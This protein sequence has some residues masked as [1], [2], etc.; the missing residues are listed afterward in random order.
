MVT[1]LIPS[2][3]NGLG[4]T[5]TQDDPV[6]VE[7]GK[8]KLTS[9][10]FQKRF[11][12]LTDSGKIPA[13][14]MQVY[15]PQYL[16]FL[17]KQMTARYQAERM[18][19]TVSDDEILVGLMA[20]NPQYFPNG[21]MG[22]D[23][24]AQYEQFLAQQ[25]GTLDDAIDETRGNLLVKK[26]ND[27]ILEAIVVTP[28]EVEAEFSKK[29]ERARIAYIAFPPGKFSDQV[30]PTEDDLHK[31]FN[32]NRGN[33]T[34]PQKTSFQ[35]VVLDQEKVEA[36][37]QFS[38]AELRKAYAGALDNFRMP[39]R[40]HVRH[41]LINAEG[42]SDA[43]KKALKTKAEDLLKQL[44][45]GADFA[46]LAKKNSQ[47]TASAEKGGDLDWL[48]RGQSGSPEFEAA[49]FA[50]KPKDFS[51][52]IT[53]QYGFQIA[54]VLEK[55]P[56]RVK[57]FEEVKAG[58]AV[59]LRKQMVPD[60]VQ[61]L[62]DQIHA[63]LQK[64][65]G[66]AEAV[67]K[68]FGADVITVP[69][70]TPGQAIPTLGASPEIDAV[71]AKMKPN[72]V[73]AVMPLPSNRLA[74]VVLTSRTPARNAEFN[75]VAEQ[76]RNSYLQTETGLVAENKAKEAA[77]R[78]R[79]G[80][81]MEKVA[82]AYKMELV[83]SSY[84]GRSDAV[85]GLGQAVYVQDAFT[86]PAGTIIGPAMIRDKNEN[87]VYKVLDKVGADPVAL[88]AEKDAIA[89]QIKERKAHEREDLMLD[90]IETRLLAEGKMKRNDKEILRVMG[91][92]APK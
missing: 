8:Y 82:K 48:V 4:T 87:I 76:V 70:A 44:K 54:Q 36:T 29:N 38:D 25:G 42:K 31:A 81:D 21:V 71:L 46:E 5:T 16:D 23:Q 86:K 64:S 12:H 78:V 88:A 68:Q 65:P 13:E 61:A 34:I 35:V 26:L 32:A 18:G 11:S 84:F 69:N 51:G 2:F 52:V 45:A 59:D 89:S 73:S 47:D 33:Y 49:V 7:V 80:E 66:S 17:T 15:F 3:G 30:K 22:P 55:E 75:E 19:L 92:Y 77:D 39:E 41:I 85:D 37:L 91:T 67:A 40:I 53:T 14:M 10:D 60:K 6:L 20:G 74:V 72:D 50:L 62:G 43:E 28:Q 9:Q 1:Y 83:T 24:R 27:G 79:A 90:S 63:A 58:L 56:A 57:P